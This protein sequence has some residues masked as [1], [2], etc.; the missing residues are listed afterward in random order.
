MFIGL[1]IAPLQA[2]GWEGVFGFTYLCLLQ[3]IFYFIP[4]PSPFGQN[5]RHTVEDSIDGLIQIGIIFIFLT[6][7]LLTR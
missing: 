3:I 2:V 4:A 5:P 7:V 6:S 1:D